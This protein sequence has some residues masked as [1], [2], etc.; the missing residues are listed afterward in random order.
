MA[1]A[2]EHTDVYPKAPVLRRVADWA[3]DTLQTI[4][5][6]NPRLRLVK[7]LQAL[8]DAELAARGIKRADIVHHVFWDKF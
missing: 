8:S 1:H 3:S 5:E 7:E 4:G 2:I 6:N